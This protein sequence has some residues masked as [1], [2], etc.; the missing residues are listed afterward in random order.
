MRIARTVAGMASVIGVGLLS[1]GQAAMA[2]PSRAIFAYS[3]GTAAG[4][5][6]LTVNTAGGP[7]VFQPSVTGTYDQNGGLVSGNYLAGVCGRSDGCAGDDLTRRDFFVFQLTGL[8]ATVT[9]ATLSLYNPDVSIDPGTG[10]PLPAGYIS[11]LPALGYA[12]FDVTSALDPV[13]GASAAANVYGDLGGGVFYG[14]KTVTAADDGQFV[15]LS[16]NT[17][18]VAAINRANGGTVSIGGTVTQVPEPASLAVLSLGF[19]AMTLARRRRRA[20]C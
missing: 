6:L 13:T 7:L 5:V 8:R 18:A 1:F 12:A 16:L 14:A 17:A 19:G 11:T 2:G 9:G 4:S 10:T 15:T 20:V 3:D